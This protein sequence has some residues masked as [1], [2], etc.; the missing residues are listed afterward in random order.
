MSEMALR[1]FIE[2][3][4]SDASKALCES[5][6]VPSCNVNT[7]SIIAGRRRESDCASLGLPPLLGFPPK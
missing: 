4:G 7:R 5:D 1:F 2:W 6:I 3:Y